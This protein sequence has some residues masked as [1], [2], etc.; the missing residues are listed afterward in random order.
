MIDFGYG[1][2][3]TFTHVITMRAPASLNYRYE[4]NRVE[5]SDVYFCVNYGVCDTLTIGSLRSHQSL[6]P[7]SFTAFI[8]RS[9][10]PFSPTK[11]YIARVDV[12]H[13][14]SV[15]LSD[16]RYN[17]AFLDAAAY[18]HRSGTKS[19]LSAHLRVGFVRSLASATS[20]ANG[21]AVLHPRKRFYAGGAQSVRGYAENQLGPR[22][23]TIS[24]EDLDS[25]FAK[26]TTGA[27][28]DT[29]TD[30]V[31]F[32][33]PN[34]GKLGDLNFKPQPLGGTSL[35]EGSVEFRTPLPF[36]Y[37]KFVGAVFLDGGLVGQS[38]R[39]SFA[40]VQN[41]AKGTG[42]VTPGFGVRYESPVGPIRF[43]I[44]I[45]P[46]TS[47]KLAVVTSIQENGRNRIVP[48]V[49]PRVYSPA[50][51]TLLNRLVLHFSIG[52]AY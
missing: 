47:E 48:L 35:V 14:S 46:K 15:T 23:L 33:D 52:Q 29:K 43:D 4:I 16:Y 37:G 19:V 51:H 32:C 42:A 26:T 13:A 31:R 20:L 38:S 24:A 21:I 30:A 36:Y 2:Q 45:N 27:P 17:R 11:G 41:I 8:D 25:N 22:I 39:Q 44:G 40:D 12:E 18:T 7:L 34:T 1:G 10:V 28:C 6:S 49:T 5:A 9:D 50:G 3:A